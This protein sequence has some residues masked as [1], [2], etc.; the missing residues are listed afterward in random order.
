[1]SSMPFWIV[2]TIPNMG[3]N[4]PRFGSIFDWAGVITW[5]TGFGLEVLADHR[6]SA[7]ALSNTEHC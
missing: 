3:S 6:M 4:I 5:L 7:S 1:M 2:N